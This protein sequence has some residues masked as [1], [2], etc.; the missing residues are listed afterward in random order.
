MNSL[1]RAIGDPLLLAIGPAWLPVAADSL[2]VLSIPLALLLAARRRPGSL[3]ARALTLLGLFLVA[4]GASQLLALG[5]NPPPPALL[6]SLAKI[7]TALVAALTALALLRPA[8]AFGATSHTNTPLEQSAAARAADLAEANARLQDEIAHRERSEAEIRRL[9]A[10]LEQRVRELQALFE[11]LPVGVGIAEDGQCQR[12]RSNPAL[13]A[14]LGLPLHANASLSASPD[15]APTNFQIRHRGRLLAPDELPMQVST[16]ENRPVRDF[17]ETIIRS[18]GTRLSVIANAI[19]L[20]D[21]QG[22]VAGCVC[23]LQDVT[24][25]KAAAETS[26]RYAAIV[27]SSQ[28]AIIGKSAEGLVTSW[29]LGAERMFGYT[30]D[31]MLGRPMDILHPPGTSE[32]ERLALNRVLQG[33]YINALETVRRRRDGSLVHVS[34]TI[35]PI[36]DEAGAIVGASKIARDI[37]ER[38]R[39][40]AEQEAMDRKLQESQKLESLGVLA[41]GIAHDFNNLLTGVL[42]NASLLRLELGAASGSAPIIDQIETASRRAAELCRQLLAYSGRGRFLVQRLD[43]NRLVEE[44]THLLTIS[45]SKHCVLRLNPARDLPAVNADATQLRQIVMNLVIN[46]SEAI[47]ERSGIVALTTGLARLDQ[48][49]LA[50]LHQADDLAPGDYVFL[51]VSDNGC[52][53]DAATL[54]RIFD[55]FFTTKFTGRGLGLAAVLGIVRGHRG[56]IKVYSEPGR[57]TTFRILLPCADGPADAGEP[58]APAGPAWRGRGTVLVV[59]D[60]ETVRAVSARMLEHCGFTVE[61]APDGREAVERFRQ[62]PAR[63]DLVLLDLTMPHLDGEETFRQLRHLRPG[64]RVLLMSGFNQ[65]EAVSRFTGKGLAGFL[66]KP[67]EA[68]ALVAAVRQVLLEN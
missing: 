25:L 47:G 22:R 24:P 48:A 60:E 32:E 3:N 18:D 54:A 36:R 34:L 10:V 9:N 15:E 26:A 64:V 8:P 59:D 14:M 2:T 46:A 41:G 57:G 20:H 7:M 35:S 63:Y 11:A 5:H 27:A 4:A 66:Q 30:A 50:T 65:Q 12:I 51:E 21:A 62:A 53:M 45:V 6:S 33:D 68:D 31:E 44:T 40:A 49:Y 42:G 28:D 39:L 29:N 23:T 16:R 43:L 56:A 38:R 37:T 58:A 17:E 19:P 61:L 55:P 13:A 52:G 67:F 1:L